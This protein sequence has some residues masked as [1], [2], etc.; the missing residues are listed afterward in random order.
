MRSDTGEVQH[1]G[2][3]YNWVFRQHNWRA[4][5]GH[6]NA[7]GWVRR[8]RWVRL[9]VRPAKP[10]KEAHE[11]MGT[12]TPPSSGTPSFIRSNTT[13]Q[14]RHSVSS[15][16]PPS[17]LTGSSDFTDHFPHVDPDEVWLGEVDSDWQRCRSLMKRFGRDG[18]KLEL[19]R[20]W[21]G[22]YHPEHKEKFLSPISKGKRRE[23]QWTEDDAPLPSEVAAADILSKE[24][25]SI[26][27]REHV[28]AVLRTHVR[29]SHCHHSPFITYS[30][31]HLQ[32]QHILHLFVFPESRAQF[33]KLLGQAG[34]LPEVN[35]GLG[36][37]FGASEIDFWSYASG[38]DEVSGSRKL[39]SPT[40]IAFP[41]SALGNGNGIG[42][43]KSSKKSIGAPHAPGSPSIL[44]VTTV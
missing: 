10:R 1:D 29:C 7:G 27:P 30:F 8:R 4:R 43:G 20:L 32:G 16:F 11:M 6:F 34:L 42:T 44:S 17:V 3:E 5:V 13:R 26:A 40:S 22:F 38:L 31:I 28:I 41:K 37:G 36:V 14:P 39:F 23:K 18:R 24:N 25:V 9:M 19:W 15:S 35:I 21:L 2:F 33:L 12:P